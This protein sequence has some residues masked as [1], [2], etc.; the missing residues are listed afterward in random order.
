MRLYAEKKKN[1]NAPDADKFV[2]YDVSE[3]IKG[4]LQN[5]I[6]KKIIAEELRSLCYD[7]FLIPEELSLWCE[8]RLEELYKD[9]QKAIPLASERESSNCFRI[10]EPTPPEPLSPAELKNIIYHCG[11]C[12]QMVNSCTSKD[13]ESFLSKAENQNNM[14]SEVSMSILR[15]RSTERYIIAKQKDAVYLAFLSEPYICDWMKKY[16]SF[17]KGIIVIYLATEYRLIN[18][19]V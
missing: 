17:D 19:K 14:F 7:E 9:F 5:K 3:Y 4:R 8:N 10:T 2:E 1:P 12:C 16:P 15:D 13:Y 6:E 11:L 18:F